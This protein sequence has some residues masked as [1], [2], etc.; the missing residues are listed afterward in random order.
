MKKVFKMKHRA[1]AVLAVLLMLIIPVAVRAENTDYNMQGIWNDGNTV[2]ASSD[3][4]IVIGTYTDDNDVK[5]ENCLLWNE[6]EIAFDFDVS[7]SGKYNLAVTYLTL[8]TLGNTADFEFT[9]SNENSISYSGQLPVFWKDCGEKRTDDYGNE[10]AP[11]QIV[12]KEFYT[13]LLVDTSTIENLPYEFTLQAGVCRLTLNSLNT[14]VVIAS[15]GLVPVADVLNYSEVLDKYDESGY[16]SAD[17]DVIII[18]GEETFRKSGKS[19]VSKSDNSSAAVSPANAVKQVINYIGGDSWANPSEEIVWQFDVSHSG[20]YKIGVM[21]QQNKNINSY[22]YRNLKIDGTTPFAECEGLSFDYGINWQFAALGGE[23]PYSFYLEKGTHTLSFEVSL[24]ELAP[25]YQ[26]L[27][28]TVSTLG[29]LYIDIAIITGESPDANR[30]YDLFDQVSGFNSRLEKMSSELSAVTDNLESIFGGATSLASAVK[31]MN[32]ILKSMLENPYT[33]QN[34]VTDYYSNYTTLSSW[35]YDMKSMPLGVDRIYISPIECDFQQKEV[36]FGQKVLFSVKRFLASFTK[37]YKSSNAL[38]EDAIKIWVNWGRDQAMVLNNL[39]SESFT[40]KTGINVN[41]EITNAS[42]VKGIMSNN[43]PDLALHL[44]RTDP[45]NFAM[46]GALYD[47]TKFDDYEQVVERF[48]DSASVP[49]EYKKGVYALP[50]T[51]SFYLM[52]YRKDVLENLGIGV[53]ETWD[54]FLSAAS[55]LQR[56]NMQAWIPYTQITTAT[57]VNTGVGGLNL[58]ASILQQHGGEFYNKEKSSCTLNNTVALSAFTFWTNIYTKHKL[59]TSAS[60]YNRFRIG[61]MPLGIE[62]YTMYTT[63]DEAAPEIEGRWGIALI[64]GTMQKDG[65]VDH[66]VSGSGTGCA[67]LESSD[68][69]EAA[70]EF[71]KWWTSAD[72]QLEYN[73]G[74]E[75]IIG[76]V[77]RTTTANIEAFSRMSWD[78]DDLEILLEQREWI[79]E[80]PEAPGSYYVARSVDQAFWNVISGERPKDMLVKWN[81]SADSEIKRKI[82]E[83]E[84]DEVNG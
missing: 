83:Y 41:L 28:N 52:F 73:N 12:V 63:L 82:A 80:I 38:D 77:S 64:P 18:E 53:P 40:A 60:F 35:L 46:R 79:S 31:N 62:P 22:S 72:T 37:E 76:T 56:N 58:F 16:K 27:T 14:P 65:S 29:D 66:T 8:D 30:D 78:S 4:D 2:I 48:G 45:V 49:Y 32:R 9:V 34:Y 3:T 1:V 11:E 21:Y 5:K 19:L 47:L 39:I 61:T 13:R 84:S 36:S 57:A 25:A 26:Q 6:G 67:V 59:P 74:V 23:E 68:K 24:G 20:L 70:W 10:I 55:V 43:A 33:A 71:L 44:P 15:V 81:D 50:D 7:V 69:K 17:G 75:T 51:Q 42:L 54:D